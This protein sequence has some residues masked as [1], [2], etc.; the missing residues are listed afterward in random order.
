MAHLVTDVENTASPASVPMSNQMNIVHFFPRIRREEG[1]VVQVVI[2]LC[3]SLAQLGHKVQL[4][5]CDGPD[6]PVAWKSQGHNPTAHFLEKS[7]SIPG[8]LSAK[9][10][11]Q[12]KQL[13]AKADVVHLHTPW[14]LGNLQL[15]KVAR[16]SCLPYVVTV[17]GML[18]DY[19]MRQKGLKKRTFLALGG[20][21]L[22]AEATAVHFTAAAE[23]EQASRWIPGKYLS[24]V[25]ACSLDLLPYENLPGT[26]PALAAFPQLAGPRQKILFLSRV[27]PKKGLELLIEAG[28]LLKRQGFRIR[29]SH[30]GARRSGLR[31]QVE[32]ACCRPR[33]RERNSL[34]GHGSWRC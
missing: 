3:L 13:A 11:E 10:V 30:S 23:M 15:A 29:A 9:G 28:A 22:F 21:R 33:P 31:G 32:A 19:C 5:T 12:F 16:K 1:G 6:V 14:E 7:P 27:H 20:R 4:A 18:D 17:H 34:P 8:R 24:V 25:Q 2:D 26:A